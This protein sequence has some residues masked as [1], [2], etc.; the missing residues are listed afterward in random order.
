M[1]NCPICN[2][3]LTD[4]IVTPCMDCGGDEFELDHYLKHRYTKYET[5]FGSLLTLCNY[6]ETDFGSYKPTYFGFPVYKRLGIQ[7]F[8]FIRELKDVKLSTDKFCL[9][10]NQRLA[11][12]KFTKHCRTNNLE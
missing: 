11:F 1:K 9:T 4:R 6:C 10:C 12:L 7:D 8:N 2:S 3:V 5:Y